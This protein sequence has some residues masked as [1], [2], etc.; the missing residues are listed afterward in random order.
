MSSRVAKNHLHWS[1]THSRNSARLIQT[2]DTTF[3]LTVEAKSSKLPQADKAVESS[4]TALK[5]YVVA[6]RIAY[7]SFHKLLKY[8][9]LNLCLFAISIL[10]MDEL[11]LR[12]QKAKEK[13]EDALKRK[14]KIMSKVRNWV[15]IHPL[16]SSTKSVN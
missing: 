11:T 5:E 9:E 13:D 8:V 15:C 4:T 12:M 3:T 16:L 6:H 1:F 2:I 14:A 7:V 10:A